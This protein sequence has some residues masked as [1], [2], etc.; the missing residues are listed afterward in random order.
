MIQET[1]MGKQLTFGDSRLLFRALGANGL[2]SLTCG[3][4][5]VVAAGPVSAFIGLENVYWTLGLGVMLVL[6]GAS[7][8]LH[9]RR[10]KVS[11][12][13]AVAISVM[14]LGWVIGSAVLVLLAPELLSR[15]GL[16]AVIAVAVIVLLFFELQA[17]ALWRASKP[18]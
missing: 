8:L 5:M 2:F 1:D 6:F 13:E 3:L 4:I 14:D 17:L 9:F 7:L 11:R 12:I 16:L 15:A 18:G 10:K